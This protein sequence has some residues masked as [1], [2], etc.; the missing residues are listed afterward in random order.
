MNN[1]SFTIGASLQSMLNNVCIRSTRLFGY[2][3]FESPAAIQE[4][5]ISKA[6]D[7]TGVAGKRVSQQGSENNCT[8]FGGGDCQC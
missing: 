6:L 8:Y 3:P 7:E 2:L 1:Y 5:N 4:A